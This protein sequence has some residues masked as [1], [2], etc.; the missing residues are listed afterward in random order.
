MRVN[1]HTHRHCTTYTRTLPQAGG[2]HSTETGRFPLQSELS[3]VR[4]V[5]V[6]SEE[7]H[8]T[9]PPNLARLVG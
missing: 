1:L 4:C 8:Q 5:G 7:R 9:E 3:S 2:A 6:S